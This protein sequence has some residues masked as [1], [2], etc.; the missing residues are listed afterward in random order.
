MGLGFDGYEFHD[1][2]CLDL[3]FWLGLDLVIGSVGLL[4]WCS[5]SVGLS[6]M[7]KFSLSLSLSLSSRFCNFC[8]VFGCFPLRLTMSIL[9]FLFCGL[10]FFD[11]AGWM[12]M[13]VARCG[14]IVDSVGS[15]REKR[16][17]REG[18]IKNCKRMNILSNK[19][20]E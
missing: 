18:I 20:V 9:C 5:S 10:V 15:V 16:A 7:V 12:V 4:W 11:D 13:M 2:L 3:G 14:V 6:F 17:V 1:G 19:C 8:L